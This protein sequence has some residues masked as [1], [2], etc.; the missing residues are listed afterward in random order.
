[1]SGTLYKYLAKWTLHAQ[2]NNMNKLWFIVWKILVYEF[3]IYI[4]WNN[5]NSWLL[6]NCISVEILFI[7]KISSSFL[8]YPV[9]FNCS[10]LQKKK[11]FDNLVDNIITHFDATNQFQLCIFGA[12]N[13]ELLKK[14]ITIKDC[15]Y[16]LFIYMTF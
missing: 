9:S 3:C 8:W 7:S 11:K 13:P 6:M 14:T 12:N 2:Q 16:T 15:L 1:M 4:F 10:F 5:Y